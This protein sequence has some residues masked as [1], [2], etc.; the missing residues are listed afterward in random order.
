MSKKPDATRPKF[1]AEQVEVW[2]IERLVPDPKN[3]RKH[4][5][6]QIRKLARIITSHG[7][8]RPVLVRPNGVIIAGHGATM[9]AQS[10]GMT[11]LPVMVANGWTAAQIRAYVIADNRIA[12]ESTFDLDVLKDELSELRLD[13][14]DLS[15]TGFEAK[16]IEQ[17][18][19]DP[20]PEDERADGDAGPPPERPVT[21]LGDVWILGRHRLVCGDCR[22]QGIVEAAFGG[23]APS[24]MVTDPPYGVEYDPDWRN[25]RLRSDG[26]KGSARAIGKVRNDDQADWSEAWALFPGPVAYVWHASLRTSEVER[27][28]L[29]VNLEPKALIVWDKG[30]HAIGRSHYHWRHELCWYTVRKGASASWHGGRKQ[31]TVWTI[32]R[33]RKS[34]TGHGTQKP[35]ECML[36]PIL[37][38][39]SPGESVFD[40]FCGS[41]TTVIA[42]ELS[43]RC[44][45]AVELDPGY[46]DVIIDRW[47]R[48]T[49]Q[50]A[51]HEATDKTFVQLID[52]RAEIDDAA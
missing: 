46:A 26:A 40:P 24:L 48:F 13:D 14:F 30:Q 36:R 50:E 17:L 44:A 49:G 15:L 1:L 41:G 43:G 4:P 19:T 33:Q 35:V 21:A 2:P 16:E 32:D 37:N 31:M 38:H 51:I 7:F 28:L 3:S 6:S 11:E 22:D 29:D 42:C 5:D 23:I 12:D 10:I 18:L 39:T 34:E 27:S 8:T 25:Q 9:A 20:I 47:Q 52:E 45:Q